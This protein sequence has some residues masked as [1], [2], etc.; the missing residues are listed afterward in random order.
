MFWAKPNY[1]YLELLKNDGFT[2]EAYQDKYV[3]GKLESSKLLH[4]DKYKGNPAEISVGT[5][6][7][8]ADGEPV[9][10]GLEPYILPEALTTPAPS[11]AP[12]A[13]P[14]QAATPTPTMKPAIAPRN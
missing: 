10:E 11:K 13:S 3:N 1:I 14:T 2:A 4:T 12:T 9:P 6:E 7:P 8:L 5:G